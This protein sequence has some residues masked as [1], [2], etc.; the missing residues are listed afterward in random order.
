MAFLLILFVSSE[1][2][3]AALSIPVILGKIGPK[4]LYV[5]DSLEQLATEVDKRTRPQAPEPPQETEEERK[6]ERIRAASQGD[7]CG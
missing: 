1:C 7:V 2:L 6:Q 5:V 4:P 3:L